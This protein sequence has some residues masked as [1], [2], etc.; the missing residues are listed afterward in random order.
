MATVK[1]QQNWDEKFKKQD[2]NVNIVQ[3]ILQ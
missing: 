1:A 3:D 2:L